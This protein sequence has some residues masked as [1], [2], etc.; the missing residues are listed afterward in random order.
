MAY[1][2]YNYYQEELLGKKV[3]LNDFPYLAELG[4]EMMNNY[5]M[6]SIDETD[7]FVMDQLKKCNARLC[8]Y[9]YKTETQNNVSSKKIGT[10][11]VTYFASKEDNEKNVYSI[12][13]MYLGAT[14]LLYGG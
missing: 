13:K 5:I 10:V 2:D 11:S 1:V 8:E 3:P 7:E 6:Q 12:I 4:A 9:L 14:G